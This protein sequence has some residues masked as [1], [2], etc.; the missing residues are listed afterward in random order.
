M[1]A[2]QIH[3]FLT[4]KPNFRKSQVNVNKV[5]TADYE[6]WTLGQLGKTNPI[7]TQYKP[8]SKPIQTQ[9]KPKQ[10][11][12]KPKRTQF[13]CSIMLNCAI[14]KANTSTGPGNWRESADTYCDRENTLEKYSGMAMIVHNVACTTFR[15]KGN[16]NS[17][18]KYA[19]EVETIQ[20]GGKQL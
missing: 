6:K 14:Y 12:F 13:Q 17:R 18:S 5:L 3:P 20:F 1:S 8:N 19:F 9:L 4:N 15:P 10:T 7:Q 2:L 16:S 11:Q